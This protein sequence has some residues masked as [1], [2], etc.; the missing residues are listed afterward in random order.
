M[1]IELFTLLFK[2]LF[3]KYGM[4]SLSAPSLHD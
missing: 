1:K 2:A 4:V 3:Q